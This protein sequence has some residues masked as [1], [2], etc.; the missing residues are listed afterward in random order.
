MR[1]FLALMLLCLLP[2]CAH[3]EALPECTTAEEVMQYLLLPTSIVNGSFRPREVQQGSIRYIGQSITRD[4]RFCT[5]Y[6]LGG[7]KG[8]ELDLT[9]QKDPVT[10]EKYTYYT[11]S[12]CT[13]AT[14]SMALSFLGIDCTPG[15]MSRMLDTR[16]ID[17]PYDE[18]SQLLGVKRV[19]YKSNIFKKMYQNYITDPEHYSPVYAYLEKPSGARHS[20]LIVGQEEGGRYLVIDS[21]LHT[22]DEQS[23]YVYSLSFNPAIRHVV[24]CTFRREYQNSTVVRFYQWYKE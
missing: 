17:E 9:L 7:E 14:Y 11:G 1:R 24:N 22:L 6:W 4:H 12:M 8:S 18:I 10:G 23:V 5:D 20:L 21:A 13:R 15:D 3:A 2:L 16:N 19:T